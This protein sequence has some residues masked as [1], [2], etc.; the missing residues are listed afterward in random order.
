MHSSK[1]Q[2]HSYHRKHQ[3]N[4]HHTHQQSHLGTPFEKTWEEVDNV[5]GEVR[6]VAEG[7]VTEAPP[8]RAVR[9]EAVV[10]NNMGRDMA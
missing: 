8:D 1:Q 10:E 4:H 7:V 2:K 9:V 6:D 3:Q 5:V